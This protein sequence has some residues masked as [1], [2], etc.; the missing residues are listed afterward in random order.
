MKTTS[1]QEVLLVND[2]V[3][4]QML[5]IGRSTLWLKVN[6]GAVPAPVTIGG[7][8]RWKV[9]DLHKFVATLPTTS[10]ERAAA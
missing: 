1:M 3:A 10:S 4:A 6:Q 9:E 7:I 8:T 5:G 2:K